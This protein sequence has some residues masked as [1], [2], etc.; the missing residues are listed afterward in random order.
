RFFGQSALIELAAFGGF[1]YREGERLKL[2]Q[3]F[4]VV[5]N[6]P[7]FGLALYFI[8]SFFLNQVKAS[9]PHAVFG[10]RFAALVNL[11]CTIVNL[12]PVMPLDGGHLFSIVMEAIFGFKGVKIA[13]VS[14]LCV[15]IAVSIFFFA[16]GAF[17]PG[18]LFLLLTFESFRALRYYKL[19]SEKDRDS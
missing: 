6:G 17:L 5:L 1:T 2:W 15:A 19:F 9:E 11:F 7:L 18:A 16:V 10:L 14:G 13:V 8:A 3:E 12:V 4:L